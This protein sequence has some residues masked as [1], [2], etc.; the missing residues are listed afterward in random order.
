MQQ[1]ACFVCVLGLLTLL[2]RAF[3]SWKCKSDNI[4]FFC[5]FLLLL[6]L[7][8]SVRQSAHCVCAGIADDAGRWCD[9]G[10][11]LPGPFASS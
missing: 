11:F 1:S 5:Y 2:V 3:K 4:A 8:F 10:H 6:F 9:I 7:L